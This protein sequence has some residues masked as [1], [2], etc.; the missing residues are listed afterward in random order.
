MSNQEVKLK[1]KVQLREKVEEPSIIQHLL[2][3]AT[4]PSQKNGY[5]L[6]QQL[7]SWD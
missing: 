2:T 1:R 6:S 7:L 5:G 4:H 3:M